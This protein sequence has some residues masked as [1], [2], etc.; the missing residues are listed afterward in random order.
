MNNE[1]SRD[2]Q[3]SNEDNNKVLCPFFIHCL[4]PFAIIMLLYFMIPFIIFLLCSFFSFEIKGITDNR[5][6]INDS[7]LALLIGAFLSSATF[8]AINYSIKRRKINSI[9]FDIIKDSLLYILKSA[10]SVI[11]LVY[12]TIFGTFKLET[13]ELINATDIINEL[14][15]KFPFFI[16]LFILLSI[17]YFSALTAFK[18]N[19]KTSNNNPIN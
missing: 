19:E 15:L 16:F 8:S 7:L 17:P 4:I 13:S 2:N 18:Y 6:I 14:I 1:P 10:A 11:L 3:N 12:I 5:S 9:N